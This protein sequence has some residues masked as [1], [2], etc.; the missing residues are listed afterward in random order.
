MSTSVYTGLTPFNFVRKHFLQI[1]LCQVHS[2]FPNARYISEARKELGVCFGNK[3]KDIWNTFISVFAW[4]RQKLTVTIENL[5]AATH[6]KRQKWLP[7]ACISPFAF[8]SSQ[9][10]G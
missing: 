6:R 5:E 4:N 9:T 2:D 3:W 10:S 8:V 1:C 7:T